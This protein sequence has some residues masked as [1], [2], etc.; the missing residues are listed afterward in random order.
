MTVKA[1][2]HLLNLFVML[3]AD[4]YE[5]SG[6]SILHK[7]S[8]WIEVIL[9]ILNSLR[10]ASMVCIEFSGSSSSKQV[11]VVHI[12]LTDINKHHFVKFSEGS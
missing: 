4:F 6:P 10:V 11:R 1:V 5:C 7:Y 12:K 2:V 9:L 3:V 8:F